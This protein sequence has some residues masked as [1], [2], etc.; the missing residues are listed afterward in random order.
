M[1]V[2]LG[3][4]GADLLYGGNDAV[5][6]IFKFNAIS[7][8]TTTARDKVY[9]FTTGIDKLDLSGIDANRTVT[10]DQAFANTSIGTT[11]KSYSIWSNVSGTDLIISADTD[12]VASTIEFQIQLMG[13]TKIALTDV[14]L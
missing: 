11:A 8:S 3:G 2:L 12:G 10:G 7:D 9:N 13:I 5:K 4:A 14:V 1:D 6:D